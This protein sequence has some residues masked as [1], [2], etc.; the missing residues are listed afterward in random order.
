MDQFLDTIFSF[1]VI[2]FTVPLM[3]MVIF[4][5]FALLGMLDIEI[6][7]GSG[8]TDNADPGGSSVLETIGLDGVPL[9]VA[10][11]LVEIYG[12][13]F[14]YMARKYIG[15]LFDGVLTATASGFVVAVLALIV[16]L[17]FAAYTSKPLRR[18]FVTHEAVGKDELIGTYCIVTTQTVTETFGQARAEDGMIYSVRTA[19]GFQIAGGSKVALIDFNELT[20]TYTVVTEAELLA[21]SANQNL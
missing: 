10:I 13:A 1:P 4:W 16:A 19:P 12:F 18:I 15:P 3:V 21:M 14:V 8:E 11:T 20:D 6:L 5:F 17:P 2:F 7:D 9:T